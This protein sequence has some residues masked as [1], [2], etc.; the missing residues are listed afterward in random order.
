MDKK[1]AIAIILILLLVI[2][3]FFVFLYKLKPN[4][5]INT[6]SNIEKINREAERLKNIEAMKALLAQTAKEIAA[7]ST[8]QKQ[9]EINKKTM[10]NLLSKTAKEIA[11]SSTLRTEQTKNIEAMQRLLQAENQ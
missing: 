8:L 10:T 11:A 4:K 7:S 5:I 1:K 6:A 3:V 9:L 2:I